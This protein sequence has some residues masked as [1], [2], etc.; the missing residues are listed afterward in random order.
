MENKA[1]N[2][3]NIRDSRSRGPSLCQMNVLL[4]WLPSSPSPSQ[5]LPGDLQAVTAIPTI[6]DLIWQEK[7]D[8]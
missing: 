8:G 5:A 1:F 6:V 2:Q 4:T 7:T 3:L